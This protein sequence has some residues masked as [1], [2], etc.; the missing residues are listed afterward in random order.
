MTNVV[1]ALVVGLALVL[2][3]VTGNHLFDPVF[4]LLLALYLLWIAAGILR[5]ALSELLDTAL[6][7]ATLD[8]IQASLDAAHPGLRGYHALRSRKSGRET[9]IDMHMLV[10]PAMSVSEAH[11]LSEAIEADLRSHVTG[12]VVTIHVDPDEPDIMDRDARTPAEGHGLH[13]HHH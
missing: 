12:A 3:G 7:E 4:A 6:P 11:L 2:V 10:D 9:H 13:L 1:Q 5:A 8:A